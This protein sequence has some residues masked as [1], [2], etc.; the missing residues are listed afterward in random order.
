MPRSWRAKKGSAKTLVSGSAIT[1]ATAS[2]RRVT[3]LRAAWFGTYPS[4]STALRTRSTSG[5]RTPSPPLTTRDTVALDTPARAATASSVGR[6]AV[7]VT[8][9]LSSGRLRSG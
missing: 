6:D 4:S 2:C 7:S 8:W 1:T 5:S 3:R 9:G